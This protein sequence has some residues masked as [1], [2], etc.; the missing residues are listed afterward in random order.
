NGGAVVVKVSKPGQDF[1]FDMPCVGPRTLES[2]AAGK[3]AALAVEAGAT[4]LLGRESVLEQ[5][6]HQGFKIVAVANP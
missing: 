4:L 2:C 5:A 1:R 6:D 3:I